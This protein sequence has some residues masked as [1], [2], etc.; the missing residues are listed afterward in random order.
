MH[1]LRRTATV[2][3]WPTIAWL[4]AACDQLD[5]PTAVVEY[6][7]V[8][9]GP[10]KVTG[11]GQI[12]VIVN[13]VEGTATFGFNAKREEG[14]NVAS[15]HLN[16]VNHVTGAHLNCEVELA[17]VTPDDDGTAQFGGYE[18]SPNSSS[19]SFTATVVDNG[20]P[21]ETDAFTIKYVDEEGKNIE[22]GLTLRS[23]NI[24]IHKTPEPV[25]GSD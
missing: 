24:Q 13:T 14:T 18:C 5:K 23:G 7:D 12:D 19:S 17:G 22:E 20:E 4:G 11:G 9:G 8:I 10:G 2:L 21:G 1:T 6:S 25:G 16:Y 15:G 3:I